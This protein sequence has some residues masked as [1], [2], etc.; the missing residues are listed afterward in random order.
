MTVA[1]VDVEP[2]LLGSQ[3]GCDAEVASKC[4]RGVVNLWRHELVVFGFENPKARRE[5]RKGR[6]QAMSFLELRKGRNHVSE[7]HDKPRERT[8]WFGNKLQQAQTR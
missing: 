2:L 1:A 4:R 3:F 5:E 6:E 7:A 8:L